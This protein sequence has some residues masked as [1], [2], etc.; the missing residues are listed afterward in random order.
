MSVNAKPIAFICKKKYR[1]FMGQIRDVLPGEYTESV[2]Q[3]FCDTFGFD[4]NAKRSKEV[5]KRIN[6][7]RQK[8]CEL[9]GKTVYEKYNKPRYEQ[10]KKQF[11]NVPTNLLITTPVKELGELNEKYKKQ[12][13]VL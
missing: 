11:P 7:L 6:E 12:G 4:P 13:I 3:M 8:K 5:C 2:E 10:L 1:E 9:E